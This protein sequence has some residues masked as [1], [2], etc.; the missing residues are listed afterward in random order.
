[1][2]T[3]AKALWLTF[4]LPEEYPVLPPIFEL[5]HNGNL[6]HAK[7]EELYTLLLDIASSTD[8]AMIYDLTQEAVRFWAQEAERIA[9]RQEEARTR[10][11][12]RRH[13][14]KCTV[15]TAPP[16]SSTDVITTEDTTEQ[17]LIETPMPL[18]LY[19]DEKERH[20]FEFIGPL[21]AV[22]QH[23]IARG[24]G[25]L[26]VENIMRQDLAFRFHQQ[27]E[28]FASTFGDECQEGIPMGQPVLTFHGTAD[29]RLS[30]IVTNGL[31]VPGGNVSHRTD[32]GYYGKG[33]YVSPDPRLSLG[34]SGDQTRVLVCAVLM[35]RHHVC[36]NV[37][38]GRG[39]AAG[40][41]SHMSS[42]RSEYVLF[43]SSQVLPC[44]L[45]SCVQAMPKVGYEGIHVLKSG[46]CVIGEMQHKEHMLKEIV[47]RGDDLCP[48]HIFFGG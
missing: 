28:L 36:Q 27:W 37:E 4:Y 31:V 25:I 18:Q 19:W 3:A 38:M 41:H 48:S 44:F 9:R 47:A 33:I 6:S 8:K 26:R 30:T 12:T 15:P 39:R 20:P 1:M 45:V 22:L 10:V 43:S 46:L 16:Q 5:E 23:M 24:I 40:Y 34:Y 13:A 2:R 32:S 29:S 11:Y 14:E 42:D 7:E 17:E 35:G 21:A